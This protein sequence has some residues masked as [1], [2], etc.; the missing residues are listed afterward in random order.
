MSSVKNADKI[1]VLKEGEIIQQ[2]THKKL[3]KEAGHYLEL[4]EKQSAQIT[5]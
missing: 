5:Q 1:I 3:L 2:G 4:A